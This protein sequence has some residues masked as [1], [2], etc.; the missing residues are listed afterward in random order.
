M[1]ANLL[2]LNGHASMFYLSGAFFLFSILV[3][4]GGISQRIQMRAGF[5]PL[6]GS[7]R[8]IGEAD[9]EMVNGKIGVVTLFGDFRQPIMDTESIRWLIFQLAVIRFRRRQVPALQIGDGA[10]EPDRR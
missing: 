6:D 2:M 3:M 1:S 4:A 5:F 7:G 8:H 10:V 9:G